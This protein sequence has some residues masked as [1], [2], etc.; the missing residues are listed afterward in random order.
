MKV[1]CIN[2]NPD[3]YRL[4]LSQVFSCWMRFSVIKDI[5]HLEDQK[6]LSDAL[7]NFGISFKDP[8]TVIELFRYDKR[9][10]V[11]DQRPGQQKV[12]SQV[13]EKAAQFSREKAKDRPALTTITNT[14]NINSIKAR[15][16]SG[17]QSPKQAA[18][19]TASTGRVSEL[20]SKF[21]S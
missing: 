8:D 10:F 18:P 14:G 19:T 17:Q 21:G 9:E 20:R 6:T 7:S 4:G 13:Q 5:M 1:F 3:F 15:F 2:D 16:E 11:I 12:G